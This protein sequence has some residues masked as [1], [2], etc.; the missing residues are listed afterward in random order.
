MLRSVLLTL[1]TYLSVASVVPA[2]VLLLVLQRSR[3]CR[4]LFSTWVFYPLLN[5]LIKHA[6]EGIRR[7]I[8]YEL[9]DLVSYDPELRREDAIRV[10]EVGVGSGRNFNH[11]SRNVRF[12]AVDH[13]TS[14]KSKFLRRQSQYAHIQLEEWILAS[15]EDLA[16]VPDS[17]VDAVIA[18]HVLCSVTD[19]RKLVSECRR[20]LAP[21]RISHA[22][23][24]PC[25]RTELR[26]P[27]S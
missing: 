24:P 17:H 25:A 8:M 10:L 13:N 14:A 1:A 19:V 15:G 18:T 23:Y 11:I 12:V 2:A 20:V 5:P 22:Q 26:Q 6:F 7:E 21:V 9:N 4:Q 3:R 27:P 16:Q